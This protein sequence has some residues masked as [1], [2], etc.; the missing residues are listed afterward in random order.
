MIKTL[1]SFIII[2]GVLVL[3]SPLSRSQECKPVKVGDPF[4]PFKLTSNL[5]L[6]EQESLNLPKEKTLS[7]EQ[8][9]SEILIIELLNV[10]CHTCQQQVPIFN[11]LWD[12]VQADTILNA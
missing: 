2:T 3:S 7:F 6:E 9:T 4:P 5:T 1:L 10:Y 11:Q 8:F 12:S